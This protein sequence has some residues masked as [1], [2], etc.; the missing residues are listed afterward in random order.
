MYEQDIPTYNVTLK[1]LERLNSGKPFY[2][3]YLCDV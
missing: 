2:I 1:I 3:E